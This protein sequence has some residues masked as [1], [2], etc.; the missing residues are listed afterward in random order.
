[1]PTKR[2]Q[3]KI[4]IFGGSG[5]IGSVAIKRLSENFDILN[6]T[7]KQLDVLNKDKILRFIVSNSP[8]QILYAAGYTNTDGAAQELAKSFTL[9]CGGIMDL[10]Y[11]A[12]RYKI[13]FHYL[14]TE[15]VFNGLKN[16]EPYTEK[17]LPNPILTNGKTKR[18]G[19]LVT[20]SS[21]S[22]NSVIR[23][24][25]CYSAF[26][27]KKLDLAR[28][29]ISKTLNNQEFTATNDQYI[30]PIYI[31]HLVDSIRIILENRGNGLYQV[32]ATDYTTP[33]DFS[34]ELVK[35]LGLNHKLIKSTTFKK[36]SKT[37]PE[38]RPQHQWLDVSKF[39]KDFGKGILKSLDEGINDFKRDF[40]SLT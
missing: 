28:L 33:Y 5:Q 36:F 34:K 31:N 6:P 16:D 3:G 12:A 19:E 39:K 14:S 20:L 22:Q 11:I 17:D 40:K 15:L 18:L 30:N 13:P 38:P 32:G 21:N 1:M 37:R 26:F 24:I 4:L 2:R 25:M 29:A 9:N 23:L 35:R 8:D 7:H 27:P 10:T